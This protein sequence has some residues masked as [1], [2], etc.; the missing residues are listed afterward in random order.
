MAQDSEVTLDYDF[1]QKNM[2]ELI[3][4]WVLQG[5]TFGRTPYCFRINKSLSQDGGCYIEIPYEM[6]LLSRKDNL[7]AV[8]SWDRGELG[9][10]NLF[11][12]DNG[13]GYSFSPLR[14]PSPNNYTVVVKKKG[15]KRGYEEIFKVHLAIRGI[16][17][18]ES[19]YAYVQYWDGMYVNIL[20]DIGLCR[21]I[22]TRKI[23]RTEYLSKVTADSPENEIRELARAVCIDT[24]IK[25]D[26]S[27]Y[28]AE[29]NADL[30]ETEMMEYAQEI[31]DESGFLEI[32]DLGGPIDLKEEFQK[33]VEKKIKDS[34]K[35]K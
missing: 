24:Y 12:G 27:K 14:M 13:W 3:G 10:F 17:E 35:S 21:F 15:Q 28:Q 19:M 8:S 23:D 9:V 34:V 22:R 11:K 26:Y 33:F 4:E 30:L 32:I 16:I 29:R 20:H 25:Y 5:Y 7:A 2:P 31:G 6:E 1:F 18:D